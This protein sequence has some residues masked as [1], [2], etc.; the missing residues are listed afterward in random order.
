MMSQTELIAHLDFDVHIRCDVE[1][2]SSDATQ[3]LRCRHCG[4]LM[5]LMCDADATI[6]RRQ[7]KTW[8]QASECQKCHSITA[9]GI[10]PIRFESFVIGGGRR[11]P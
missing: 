6:A 11:G 5:L 2:C 7:V 10:S 8:K 4:D 1:K 9:P 3:S